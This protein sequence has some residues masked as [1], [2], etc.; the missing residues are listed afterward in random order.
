MLAHRRHVRAPGVRQAISADPPRAVGVAQVPRK[1]RASSCGQGRLRWPR[2][3]RRR[4]SGRAC[5]RPGRF[6][7]RRLHPCRVSPPGRWDFDEDLLRQYLRDIRDSESSSEIPSLDPPDCRS[8]DW[9]EWG[10]VRPASAG[11]DGSYLSGSRYPSPGPSATPRP[12]VPAT[13]WVSRENSPLQAERDWIEDLRDLR[14]SVPPEAQGQFVYIDDVLSV[15]PRGA[16]LHHVAAHVAPE[17]QLARHTTFFL[18]Q[19]E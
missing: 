5:R 6:R 11:S 16:Y 19:V 8:P 9:S 12:G 10:P 1:W 3:S 7:H 14:P 13:F 4:G 17:A 15:T 2:T 18:D